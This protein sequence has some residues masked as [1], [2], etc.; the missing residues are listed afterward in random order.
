[1][2]ATLRRSRAAIGVMALLSLQIA[3]LGQSPGA[4]DWQTLDTR[5]ADLYARGDLPQAIAAAEEALR[6]AASPRESGKSLDRLGFLLYTSGRLPEGEKYLRESLRVRETAFGADSLDY[7]ETANDLA[8]LLRDLR[9]MDESKALAERSVTNRTRALGAGDL[10]VAESLNTQ[11]SVHA[12]AGDYGTAVSMFERAMAIHE[13][14]PLAER[15]NEE[16]GTLCVNAAGTYQRLGKYE[17]AE[18]SFEKGLDALRVKPGID[19]PAY[20]ASLLAYAGLKVDLGRYVEAERMYD[21]GGRLVAKEL[22]TEHPVYATLLNNRGALFQT[23]GNVEAA[24]ADYRQSLEL[25]R[26]LYGPGSLLAASTLRNLAHLTYAR[27]HTAGERLLS[28]AV[29]VYARLTNPPPFDY[30]SV[31]LGLGRAQLDRG[32][33]SDAGTTIEKGLSVAREGLGTRHPLYAAAVRDAGLVAAANGD[34]ARAE[35]SLRDAIAIA[36]DVHG[37]D[38]PDLAGFLDALAGFHARQ[39]NVEASLPLY[40]RS[41]E[42]QDRFLSDIL[43]I[44]SENFKAASMASAMDPLPALIAFQAGAGDRLPAARVLAFEAVTRRKGRVLE[45][46]RNWRQRLHENAPATT[47]QQLG[48]WEAMLECRTSLTVALGYREIR[49]SVVGGCGLAGTDLEGRYEKLLSDLR[50]RRTDDVAAEAVRAIG[51]LKDR[52]DA[53]EASLNRENGWLSGSPTHVSLDEIRQQLGADELLVEYVSYQDAQRSSSGGRRY[54]AFVL[55]SAGALGWRD[56]GPAPAIDSSVRDLLEAANDWSAAMR[57]HESQTTRA[58][59]VTAQDAVANLS[60]RVWAPLKPLLKGRTNVRRLRVAPDG[61]LNLVPF[62]ALSDGHDLIERYAITYVPAGRDI[63]MQASGTIASGAP[64]VVVSPGSSATPSLSSAASGTFRSDALAR[65]SAAT[66]E[67]ADLRRMVPHAALYSA[68]DATERHVKSVHGPSLLHIVGHGVIRGGDVMSLSAIVLEEAYGRGRDSVDDGMLTATELQNVDLRGTEMLVLSQCQ[69][70]N[71]VASI[72][73]GVYGMRRAA[74]IAG[75]RSFVAPLWNVEDRVQR[76]LMARFYGGL[77]MG[78]TR[79]EALRRAKLQ[80]RASPATSSFLY[81][82]PVILSGSASALPPA[83]FR[84]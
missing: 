13:R 37:P 62:E 42:I 12:L 68:A 80:L 64:V 30:V 38:H 25:K 43:Q 2:R 47:I 19:H 17:V 71:G 22:G 11:G 14:R 61:L 4:S 56:I 8:Q 83:I 46:V 65:L 35:R 10:L 70:A 45:Q 59:V 16:Y 54:G 29:D 23:I 78:L 1:M 5:A 18:V 33:T 31:L 26:K 32:A 77:A 28:E 58:A 50:T 49:P 20:A 53:L 57:N 3:V 44:G 73:E 27:D 6:V 84:P 52:G 15:S 75:A 67:A 40:R 79:S 82:A 21:E 48:E 39:G 74:A 36:E 34:A 7:A 66:A 41:F 24:E 81:W 51:V 76:T 60:T 9:R 69:M 72:G 63:T 55:D